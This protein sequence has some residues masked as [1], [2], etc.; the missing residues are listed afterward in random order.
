[1]GNKLSLKVEYLRSWLARRSDEDEFQVP[2]CCALLW[3]PLVIAPVPCCAAQ[4]SINR[5]G[6]SNIHGMLQAHDSDL[7]ESD[8]SGSSGSEDSED[9][10]GDDDED[11]SDDVSE[12]SEDEEEE[13]ERRARRRAGR[14]A[15]AAASRR[16]AVRDNA[17][18]AST[19]ARTPAPAVEFAV[20]AA[21]GTAV[22]APAE[23][24]QK[25]DEVGIANDCVLF[26][27]CHLLLRCH[28]SW[29]RTRWSS[30]C[31]TTSRA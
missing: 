6:L 31:T 13:A 20:A 12:E 10:S 26:V 2:C 18:A 9:F 23:P 16:D 1:M 30:T 8:G 24:E 28:Q 14:V 15:V 29:R 11:G 25:I 4:I 3:A 5:L 19:P 17:A 27:D 21:G 7:D 22:S